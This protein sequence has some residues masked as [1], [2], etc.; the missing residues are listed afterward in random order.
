MYFGVD[1][2][3]TAVKWA[4]IADDYQVLKSGVFA[5]P[6]KGAECL[7]DRIASV[8]GEAAQICQAVGISI[9]GTLR[10][11]PDGIVEGGGVLR[12]LDGI[13]F[14]K[15]VR[16]RC[17]IPC[18]VENDGKSCA[19]GEY[20]AGALK[21]CRTGVVL[22]L[23]TGIGGGIVIDGKVY[24]GAHSFAGEFS[25]ILENAGKQLG[26]GTMMGETCGWSSGLKAELIRRKG[27]PENTQMDGYQIFDLVNNGDPD[28]VGAL[29]TYCS[30]LA[31]QIHNLQTILDPDIFAIGGGISNQPVL[32]ETLQKAV[33]VIY[34]GTAFTQVPIPKIV[35][36]QYGNMANILGAV[37]R[38]RQRMAADA[39]RLDSE[40]TL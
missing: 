8:Y 38:C 21:G 25:F 34:E 6:Y 12:F 9:P 17:G 13:P 39:S 2:G 19:L 10:D 37:R 28:A 24:K 14:G 16:D 3:E 20:T 27:L 36:C 4:V 22:V 18:F 29:E 26:V 15:L 30:H 31:V 1:V 35:R 32:M 5:T 40:S 7:A 11:D 23:G 33:D